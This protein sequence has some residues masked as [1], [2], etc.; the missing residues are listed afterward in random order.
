[1][2]LYAAFLHNMTRNYFENQNTL[3]KQNTTSLDDSFDIKDTMTSL[4][5]DFVLID[6]IAALK[7]GLTHPM[8]IGIV[9]ETEKIGYLNITELSNRLGISRTSIYRNLNKIR[10]AKK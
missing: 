9:V 8:Q 6:E 7:K 2:P 3:Q 10:K 1:M 4:V 5:A